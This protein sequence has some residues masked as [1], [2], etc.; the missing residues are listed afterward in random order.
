MQTHKSKTQ[1]AHKMYQ[2]DPI[3]CAIKKR[4]QKDVLHTLVT[5]I[6]ALE[7]DINILMECWFFFQVT[8]KVLHAS[9]KQHDSEEYFHLFI[10]ND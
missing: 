6:R 10:E 5:N 1:Q 4:V 3:M 2:M 7:S 8:L 9:K